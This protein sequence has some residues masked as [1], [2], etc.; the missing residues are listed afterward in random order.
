MKSQIVSICTEIAGS[1]YGHMFSNE[2]P[3]LSLR[4]LEEY[5]AQLV[6]FQKGKVNQKSL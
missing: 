3:D 4:R 1:D 5:Q 6:T 2:E